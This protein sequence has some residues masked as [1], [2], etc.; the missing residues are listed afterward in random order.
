VQW[1]LKD[2]DQVGANFA[3]L[4]EDFSIDNKKWWVIHITYVHYANVLGSWGLYPETK[5]RRRRLSESTYI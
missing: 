5:A 1:R 4:S 3:V 2:I